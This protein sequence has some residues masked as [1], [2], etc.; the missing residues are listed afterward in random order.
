MVGRFDEDAAGRLLLEIPLFA[1]PAACWWARQ[2]VEST[3]TSQVIKPFASASTWSR[4]RIRAQVPSRCQ[5][6]KRS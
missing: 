3:F 2:T 6:R 1:A 5:R 4:V